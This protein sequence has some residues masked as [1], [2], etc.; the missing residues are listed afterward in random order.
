MQQISNLD[1]LRKVRQEWRQQGLSVALVPTMGNLHSGHLKLVKKA[2]ELADRVIVSIYVNPMQFAANEDLDNY[3]RTL[4]EDMRAL[5][6]LGVEVVLTPNNQDIYPRGLKQQTLVEVPGI[7]DILCGASR[8]GHFR[9]VATIVCKLFNMVQPEHAVFGEKDFQQLQVIRLMVQDLSIPLI[10]HGVATEREANGLAKSSRNGYL[11]EQQKQTAAVIYQQLQ[12]TAQQ[13][14]QGKN[15]L[16]QLEADASKVIQSAGLNVEYFSIRRR[17]DLQ[18]AEN[19]QTELV[20]LAAAKLGN[21][22]LIDN[23]LC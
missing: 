4:V 17:E 12:R 2:R 14:R 11:T 10:V 5:Q 19:I 23:L 22:R 7:S 1:E 18:P 9:G 20:I 13:I 21:T 6:E 3:P 15:N 8:K 16:H